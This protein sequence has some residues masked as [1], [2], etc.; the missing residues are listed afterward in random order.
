[1]SNCWSLPGLQIQASTQ[2][3]FH[4]R[5]PRQGRSRPSTLSRSQNEIRASSFLTSKP[6]ALSAASRGVAWGDTRGRTVLRHPASPSLQLPCVDGTG[7]L[8]I[9]EAES[10]DFRFVNKRDPSH[11]LRSSSNPQTLKD[12]QRP[13]LRRFLADLFGLLIVQALPLKEAR[14]RPKSSDLSAT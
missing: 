12:P 6:K 4:R 5:Y 13:S 8:C 2:P 1:M 14:P 10:L 3:R 9:K 7:L 11:R